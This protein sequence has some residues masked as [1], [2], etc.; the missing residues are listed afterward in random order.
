MRDTLHLIEQLNATL[1][2][3][4]SRLV[5]A[6]QVLGGQSVST[7]DGL[8]VAVQK[9]SGVN[10]RVKPGHEADCPLDDALRKAGVRP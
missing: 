2:R 6:Y 9:C 3:A 1:E 10:E 8:R 7:E 4:E 5:A